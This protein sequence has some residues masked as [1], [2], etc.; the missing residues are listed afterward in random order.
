MT[1]LHFEYQNSVSINALILLCCKIKPFD[2]HKKGI[3]LH[4]YLI[5]HMFEITDKKDS[6]TSK[7]IDV[8]YDSIL[9]KYNPPSDLE[10]DAMQDLHYIRELIKEAINYEHI[11]VDEFDT[12][13]CA[14]V[15]L[16][17]TT[18]L[19]WLE[20]KFKTVSTR[21]HDDEWNKAGQ[22]RAYLTIAVLT[23]LFGDKESNASVAES[24]VRY[25]I[26]KNIEKD[27]QAFEKLI[28]N[29]QKTLT[30][31]EKNNK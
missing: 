27:N 17:I 26:D 16:D 2:I 30:A 4:E 22:D 18:A 6:E 29:A 8:S 21:I 31:L 12:K 5:D 25:L 13:D 28:S 3:Q 23:N 10:K 19:K 11:Q 20:D 7:T 9:D 1:N 24:I 15:R 14:E